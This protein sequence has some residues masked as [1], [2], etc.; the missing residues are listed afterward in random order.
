MTMTELDEKSREKSNK[1]KRQC[2]KK[3]AIHDVV[4]KSYLDVNSQIT[5]MASYHLFLV[6]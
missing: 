4:R 2:F 6:V 5:S 3:C 1:N